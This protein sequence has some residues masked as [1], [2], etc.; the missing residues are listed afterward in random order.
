MS[1]LCKPFLSAQSDLTIF[2]FDAPL[3][4]L[5]SIQKPHFSAST[6]H[7]KL[8]KRFELN[9]HKALVTQFMIFRCEASL[10][11]SAVPQHTWEEIM[12]TINYN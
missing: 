4:L 5:L 6:R 2:S 7:G 11:E 8:Y 10:K 12:S 9:V 1:V 3:F